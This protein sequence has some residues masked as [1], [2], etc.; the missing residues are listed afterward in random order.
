M[1]QPRQENL[2]EALPA[3]SRAENSTSVCIVH[4]WP[5]GKR[6]GNKG[7]QMVVGGK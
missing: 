6:V 5:L 2:V 1:Q 3:E 4:F 7:N